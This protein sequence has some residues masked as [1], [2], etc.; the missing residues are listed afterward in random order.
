M[1]LTTLEELALESM[2]FKATLLEHKPLQ[3]SG[4]RG[5]RAQVQLTGQLN[6]SPVVSAKSSHIPVLSSVS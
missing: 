6:V 4:D 5:G 1:I 3:V 2:S